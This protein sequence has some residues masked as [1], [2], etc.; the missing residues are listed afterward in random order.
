[1]HGALRA[2]LLP[3]MKSQIVSTGQPNQSGAGPYGINHPLSL[4][5]IPD[6][7]GWEIEHR[8]NPLIDVGQRKMTSDIAPWT[9]HD[10]VPGCHSSP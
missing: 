9:S 5:H 8:R 7:L 4:R 6:A 10:T 1:M 2:L 3:F